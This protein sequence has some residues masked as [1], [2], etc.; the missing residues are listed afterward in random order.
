MNCFKFY[1]NSTKS[2][3][4]NDIYIYIYNG[5]RYWKYFDTLI[6]I[7]NIHYIYKNDFLTYIL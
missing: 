1:V 7:K 5:L 2:K 6:L 3:Q 4:L